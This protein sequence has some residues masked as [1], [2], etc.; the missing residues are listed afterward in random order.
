M[1]KIKISNLNPVG[2]ELFDDYETYMEDI[3]EEELNTLEIN[4]KGTPLIYVTTRY[5]ASIVTAAVTY[6]YQKTF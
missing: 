6:S 4:G 1:T 5:V 2:H 3:S